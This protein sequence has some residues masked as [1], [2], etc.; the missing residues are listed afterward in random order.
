VHTGFWWGGLKEGG[1]FE[2][3]DVLKCIYK[4]WDGEVWIGLF[5]FRGCGCG[6]EASDSINYRE[7]HF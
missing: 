5:W 7:I 4:K 1:H 2:D 3:T 6:N